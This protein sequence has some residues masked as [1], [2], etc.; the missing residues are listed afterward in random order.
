PAGTCDNPHWWFGRA[1]KNTQHV[2]NRPRITRRWKTLPLLQRVEASRASYIFDTRGCVGPVFSKAEDISIREVRPGWTPGLPNSHLQG[3]V[4]ANRLSL[5]R[6]SI[7][8]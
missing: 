1:R 3:P 8:R 4:G 5:A 7:G 6:S 2:G